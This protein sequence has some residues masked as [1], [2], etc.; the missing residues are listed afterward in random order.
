MSEFTRGET[1]NREWL[2]TNWS[3]SAL[4]LLSRN[5]STLRTYTSAKSTTGR[6]FLNQILCRLLRQPIEHNT[7][8]VIIGAGASGAQWMNSLVPSR[9][10]ASVANL[11]HAAVSPVA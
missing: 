4:T 9:S 1:D 11:L 6:R 10:R 5:L 3:T 2:T 8:S 7:A